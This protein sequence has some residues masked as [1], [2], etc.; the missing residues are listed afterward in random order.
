MYI[1]YYYPR[2]A[3]LAPHLILEHLNE[4]FELIKVDRENNQQKSP[5]ILR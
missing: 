4:E 3:S 1:L 2:N 5:N